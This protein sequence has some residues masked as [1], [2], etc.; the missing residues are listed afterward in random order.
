MGITA[1]PKASAGTGVSDH[2]QHRPA[3]VE[4]GHCVGDENVIDSAV[5]G[6]CDLFIRAC[7]ISAKSLIF[8]S[9]KRM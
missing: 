8:K 4:C 7:L 3:P 6:G 2:D 5:G 9:L 1:Y